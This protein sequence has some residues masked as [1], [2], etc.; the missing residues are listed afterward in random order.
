MLTNDG[1][2]AVK[3]PVAAAADAALDLVWRRGGAAIADLFTEDGVFET[4]MGDPVVGRDALREFASN[5]PVGMMHHFFTD[6]VIDIDGDTAHV[7]HLGH[8]GA[9]YRWRY[10]LPARLPARG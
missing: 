9:Q 8:G 1:G 5:V 10:R 4:G 7:G 6:H 3:A 2:M